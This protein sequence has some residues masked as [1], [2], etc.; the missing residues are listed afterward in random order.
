MRSRVGTVADRRAADSSSSSR[1]S[2]PTALITFVISGGVY[3]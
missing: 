2:K 1:L 3:R